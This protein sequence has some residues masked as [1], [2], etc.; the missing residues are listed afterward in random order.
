MWGAASSSPY[1]VSMKNRALPISS[2]L[3]KS[4]ETVIPSSP[5]KRKVLDLEKASESFSSFSIESET[6]IS[7]EATKTI[8]YG[9]CMLDA[10]NLLADIRR[11]RAEQ[12]AHQAQLDSDIR[13]QLQQA[14]L[15]LMMG[16]CHEQA[17]ECNMNAMRLKQER[18]LVCSAISVLDLHILTM[19]SDLEDARS[20]HAA[21]IDCSEH[22]FFAQELKDQL[23]TT[24]R[25]AD[26]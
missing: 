25:H 20:V 7:T 1:K 19:E 17:E 26:Q 22:E 24:S 11:A 14:T 23:R 18:E 3:K 9:T 21:V 4:L 2:S 5:T 12:A 16:G 6:P 13:E 8:E 15:E 10:E